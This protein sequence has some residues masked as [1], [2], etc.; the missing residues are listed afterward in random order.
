ME[1]IRGLHNIRD[2]HRPCCAT[3]GNFD[4]IHLGHQHILK[5]LANQARYDSLPAT[6][7]TFEPY[8]LEFFLQSKA[9]PRLMRLREKLPLLEQAGVD[10]V[11]CIRFNQSFANMT[12]E[13]FIEQVLN[14]QLQVRYLLVGDDFRFGHKRLGDT[15]MLER[16]SDKGYF[17]LEIMGPY[18]QESQRVSSTRVR[19]L[20]QNNQLN[21]A[22]EL[23]GRHFFMSGRVAH[24][25]KLGRQLGFPTANIHLHRHVVPITGVYAVKVYGLNN[26]PYFGVAN[27]GNRPAVGGTRCILEIYIFNFDDNIYGQYVTVQFWH[28][29]RQERDY[30]SMEA[31]KQD[32]LHD[33]QKAK[34]YFN[35]YDC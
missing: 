6:V 20:L 4:G 10:Q 31:L 15:N 22:N 30:D 5:K 23:L 25:D 26:E 19:E 12:A 18:E 7:I 35:C 17:E 8:P 32:I 11:L 13:R 21:K 14:E 28:F 9:Q 27:V 16:Y 1:L 24:G 3:I 34:A 29:I 2:R 33:A